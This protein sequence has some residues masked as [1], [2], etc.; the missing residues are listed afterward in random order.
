METDWATGASEDTGV[1]EMDRV[2]EGIY[3]GD[4]SVDSLH[5]ILYLVLY[6][7]SYHLIIYKSQT[8][9]FTPFEYTGFLRDWVWNPAI[10]W[11]LTA[12]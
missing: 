9:S 3:S 11:I 7:I 6:L 2:T 1:A 4:P 12:W 5:G 10:T 8:P